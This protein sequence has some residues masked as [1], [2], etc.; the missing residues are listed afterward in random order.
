MNTKHLLGSLGLLCAA[1]VAAPV[2]AEV[3]IRDGAD[4][5]SEFKSAKTRADVQTDLR[6][7]N[8]QG[9]SVTVRDGDEAKSGAYG[10]A[11]SRYSMRTRD[12]VRADLKNPG[13]RSRHDI[14]DNLYFGD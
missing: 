11:G 5:F 7:A 14:H 10:V 6:N 12:E 3:G 8:G 2:F 1:T 13:M 4:Q 9:T